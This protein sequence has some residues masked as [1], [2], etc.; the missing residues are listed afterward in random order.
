MKKM[1]LSFVAM[2]VCLLVIAIV[3]LI[4]F[5]TMADYGSSYQDKRLSE[6]RDSV[7]SSIAQCYALEG[8]YPPDLEYLEDNYGLI[9]DRSHYIYH[10]EMFASNIFPDVKVL[11]LKGAEG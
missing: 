1:G 11:L 8:C 6:V 10:Y 3:A 5:S 7:L 9:M 2:I 4:A